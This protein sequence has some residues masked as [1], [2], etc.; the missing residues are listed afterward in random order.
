MIMPNTYTVT[1]AQ[2][3]SSLAE[4]QALPEASL[5]QPH[6]A[7]ALTVAALCQYPANPNACLEMLDYLRGPRPLTPYDKQFIRDRFRGKD[8]VPRSYFAGT[9]PD[10]N[11]TPAQPYTVTFFENAYSRAE[12]A[13]G[14]I[15]LHVN[16]SGA[17]S[18]HQVKL[19]LKPST[20]QWFL[21]EQYL[22]PDIRAPKALDPWA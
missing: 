3:P 7:A 14:Y 17:D 4:L 5:A 6:F 13:Q 18:P 11:Y 8:Y 15:M 22:L 16:S 19:R 20:G 21:W 1:F 9:S 10:N 12:Y 2:L